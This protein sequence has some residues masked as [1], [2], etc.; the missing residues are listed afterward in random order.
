VTL[1]PF[2]PVTN[3]PPVVAVSPMDQPARCRRPKDSSTVGL[4]IGR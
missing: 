3:Q 2:C 1:F 4:G